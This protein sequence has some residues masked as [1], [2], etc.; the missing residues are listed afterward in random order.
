MAESGMRSKVLQRLRRLHGI[1]VENPALPGTAD[2]N[3][4]EGWIELK[5]LRK[6]PV[7]PGSVVR[8]EHYT[9]QQRIWHIKRRLAGGQSWLMIQCRLEWLLIDGG[10]AAKHLNNASR[11]KLYKLASHVWM[12]GLPPIEEFERCILQKQSAFSFTEDDAA[13]IR[14]KLPSKLEYDPTL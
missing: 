7:L 8:F 13:L 10:V 12:K 6:W 3:Y 1:A 4:V 5:W 9:P 14:T 2:V 11:A